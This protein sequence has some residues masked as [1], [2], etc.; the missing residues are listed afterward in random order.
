MHYSSEGDG[1]VFEIYPLGS[2]KQKT[3]ATRLGFAVGDVDT[4]VGMAKEMGAEIISP[5]KDSEWGRRAVIR[6]PEGHSVELVTSIK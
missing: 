6:D 1:P 5:P 3:T 4:T 2:S